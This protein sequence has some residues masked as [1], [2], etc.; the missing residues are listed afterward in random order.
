MSWFFITE[1]LACFVGAEGTEKIFL[2]LNIMLLKNI[3][4]VQ[5]VKCC[6][7]KSQ[8]YN[9]RKIFMRNTGLLKCAEKLPYLLQ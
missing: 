4:I 6:I 2:A 5:T 9:K 1:P 7:L 8:D 3:K